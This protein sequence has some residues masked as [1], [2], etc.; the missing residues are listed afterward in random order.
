MA[1]KRKPGWQYLYW[2]LIPISWK[3]KRNHFCERNIFSTRRPRML[4]VGRG[5]LRSSHKGK[6]F[7]ICIYHLG[8]AVEAMLPEFV[9][10]NTKQGVMASKQVSKS[11][12]WNMSRNLNDKEK[13]TKWICIVITV[14]SRLNSNTDGEMRVVA[15]F[16]SSIAQGVNQISL[17]VTVN[18]FM[19]LVTFEAHA[20]PKRA[21]LGKFHHSH[22]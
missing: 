20:H 7:S 8:K 3:Q 6:N 15:D 2:S 19:Y 22:E 16:L 5:W 17:Y 12:F 18:V 4:L 11:K 10:F 14:I 9:L 13:L 1:V 21:T